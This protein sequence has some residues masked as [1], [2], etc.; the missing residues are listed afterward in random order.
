MSIEEVRN[1]LIELYLCVKVRKSEDIKNITPEFISNEKKGLKNI[2]L[3]DII[4][5]IQN[6]IDILVEMKS[7]EKYEEKLEKEQ[8]YKNYINKEDPQDPNGLKLYEGM[9]IQAEKKIRGHIRVS[10]IFY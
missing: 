8:E 4:N 5:Y 10:N 7:L 6:S 9:L 1:K 3:I 2:P